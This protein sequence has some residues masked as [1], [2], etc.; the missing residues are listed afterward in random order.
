MVHGTVSVR[1]KQSLNHRYQFMR[2][3]L[4]IA[5]LSSLLGGCNATKSLPGGYKLE[6]WEDGHKYYLLGLTHFKQHGGGAIN[7]TVLRIAW[8]DEVIAADRF[9]TFRGDQDGWM[10]LNA[11]THELSGPLSDE[12]FE[13][14]R[15]KNSLRVMSPKDAWE[16]L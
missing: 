6:K 8:N 4:A 10:I 9:S 5:F 14:V 12:Q 7:G 16:S 13:I 2:Y 1:P 3:F 11:K 15:A